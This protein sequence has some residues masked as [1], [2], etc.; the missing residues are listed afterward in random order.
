M[1]FG[2]YFIPTNLFVLIEVM[3][4]IAVILHNWKRARQLF[5]TSPGFTSNKNLEDQFI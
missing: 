2:K 3:I 4:W 1:S 5:T